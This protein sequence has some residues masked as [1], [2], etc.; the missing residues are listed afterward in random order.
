MESIRNPEDS[1]EKVDLEF[2]HERAKITVEVLVKNIVMPELI[3][4]IFF[5]LYKDITV[6]NVVK[7]LMRG[8]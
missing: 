3:N 2:Y 4:K 6:K 1:E 7:L 8:K 5:E